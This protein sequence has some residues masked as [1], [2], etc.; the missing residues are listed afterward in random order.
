ME[1][2]IIVTI[3]SEFVAE[4]SIELVNIDHDCEHW[5]INPGNYTGDKT[6]TRQAYIDQDW[7]YRSIT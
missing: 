3:L 2:K 7:T 5:S 6:L 4:N 1:P